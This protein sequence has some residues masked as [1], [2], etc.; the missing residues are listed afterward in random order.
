M[1]FNDAMREGGWTII[2]VVSGAGKDPMNDGD[3]TVGFY[4]SRDK[5]V[6]DGNGDVAGDYTFRIQPDAKHEAL[7]KAKTVKG[8]VI[9]TRPTDEIFIRDPGY[10]REIDILKAQ[11]KLTMQPDGKLKGYLGGYRPWLPI[12]QGWVN[13]RGPVIEALTWV[14]LPDVWYALKRGADYSPTGPKGEKTHIS[15][16]LR[17]EAVP[18][19]VMTPDAKLQ[20]ADVR[21]YK[22]LAPPPAAAPAGLGSINIVDGIVVPRGKPAVSQTAEMLLPPRDGA[23]AGGGR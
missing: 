20:V 22:A 6:K 17:I 12:Y 19:F 21:S 3:V 1:Q 10:S 15:F 2:V 8:E 4:S 9:S 5:L 16:A 11:V 23:A 18:A 7:F 13:A 14:R